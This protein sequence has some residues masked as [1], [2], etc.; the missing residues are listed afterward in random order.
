MGRG[1][2]SNNRRRSMDEWWTEIGNDI[3]GGLAGNGAMAPAELG[4]RL[5]LSEG[6]TTSLPFPAGA[7]REGSHWPG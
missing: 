2:M 5:G 7:R 4:L 6:A 3:L 1:W